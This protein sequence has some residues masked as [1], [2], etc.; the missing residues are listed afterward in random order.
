MAVQCRRFRSSVKS[1]ERLCDEAREFASTIP[2]DRLISISVS[3]DNGSGIVFVWYW[4]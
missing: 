1:W 3:A 2:R 4:E